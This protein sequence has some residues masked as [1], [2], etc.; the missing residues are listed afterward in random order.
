MNSRLEP[1]CAFTIATGLFTLARSWSER[2]SAAYAVRW[3]RASI[4]IAAT[5][6]QRV[7]ARRAWRRGIRIQSLAFLLKDC[8]ALAAARLRLLLTVPQRGQR[9]TS[10][11]VRGV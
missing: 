3:S 6:A 7:M 8:G 11:Y 2:P 10:A 4:A 1:S 5:S 9:Y